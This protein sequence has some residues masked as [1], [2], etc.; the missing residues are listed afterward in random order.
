MISRSVTTIAGRLPFRPVTLPSEAYHQ[1]FRGIP[2]KPLR[3]T[4]YPQLAISA[5]YETS[6]AGIVPSR[7]RLSQFGRVPDIMSD[8]EASVHVA[9]NPSAAGAKSTCSDSARDVAVY[10]PADHR[11]AKSLPT[12]HVVRCLTAN[13]KTLRCP[14]SSLSPRLCLPRD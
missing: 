12:H 5:L 11:R 8:V 1:T 2:D 4:A 13:P 3:I 14:P 6:C 9:G 7:S 10:Q